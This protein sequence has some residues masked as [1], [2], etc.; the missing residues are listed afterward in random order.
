MLSRASFLRPAAQCRLLS[1]A[2][3]VPFART[4]ALVPSL[5]LPPLAQTIA[6]YTRLTSAIL[7]AAQA[8]VCPE[9][10]TCL[11]RTL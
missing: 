8:E 3:A 1:S 2:Q 11:C 5:P 9:S 10:F 7:P 4:Q 6:K